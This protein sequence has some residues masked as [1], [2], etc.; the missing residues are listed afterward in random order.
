MPVE[1]E[2]PQRVDDALGRLVAGRGPVAQLQARGSPTTARCSDGQQLGDSSSS[3]IADGLAVDR[4]AG[5]RLDLGQRALHRVGVGDPGRLGERAQRD[6]ERERLLAGQPQRPRHAGVEDHRDRLALEGQ[7]DQVAGAVAGQAAHP[8][9]LQVAAQ[10]RLGDPEVRGGLGDADARAAPAGT[11]PAPA[12]AAGAARC[13]SRPSVAP[14]PQRHRAGRC[15]RVD[16][17]G[18]IERLRGRARRS[19]PAGPASAASEKVISS[20]PSSSEQRDA[21]QRRRRAAGHPH[22]RH[23]VRPRHVGRPPSPAGRRF[24]GRSNSPGRPSE[25]DRPGDARQPEAARLA[26][27]AVE[28]GDVP[29]AAPRQHAPRFERARLG[30]VARRTFT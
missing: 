4:A 26:A 9:Q 13:S 2:H 14:P 25:L 27:V 10:L 28:P 7:V 19:R 15:T 12:A 23:R 29:A 21:A 20:S 3:A 5:G 8:Q 18:R 16:E 24:S 6:D 17:F 11:A 1:L 22:V 30:R